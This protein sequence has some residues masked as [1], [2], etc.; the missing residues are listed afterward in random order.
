MMDIYE[1]S[2]LRGMQDNI[3]PLPLQK[4]Q[5]NIEPLPL[6]GS[7]SNP[8]SA[9]IAKI[10]L[11]C[12]FGI[13]LTLGLRESNAINRFHG[14]SLRYSTPINGQ[15]AYRARQYSI[16][17]NRLNP[18]WPTFWRE[19]IAQLAVGPRTLQT[20]SVSFAG[21]AALVWPAE[22]IAGSAPSSIDARGIAVSEPLAY[23]LWGS[24][25]IIGMSVTVNEQPRTVRGVFRGTA[26][27]ALISFHIEDTSQSWTAVELA[28]GMPHPTRSNATGFAV[29]S[30][31]GMPDNIMMRGPMALARFAAIFPI[32]IPT[33]YTL[34]MLVGFVKRYYPNAV[35]PTMFAGLI[36]FAVLLPPLLNALPPWIIPTHWSDFSFWS[37]LFRQASDGLREFLSIPPML[38]DIEL[39]IR[40]LR[41]IGILV[42]ALCVG[43]AACFSSRRIDDFEI[44][45]AQNNN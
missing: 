16:E 36:L 21:D 24:T 22:F 6:Q 44:Y 27:L 30:G 45:P 20:H 32:L 43:M 14:I 28:G 26:E 23:S 5:H 17:N 2:S 39:R 40:L 37:L 42:L 12:L 9:F 29:L 13:L 3:L 7:Q 10:I 1:D 4:T 11:W 38:R 8:A 18:F 35:T 34:I 41:Q 19:E 31:L 15:A 25:D 33:V